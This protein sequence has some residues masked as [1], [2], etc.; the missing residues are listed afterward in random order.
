MTEFDILFVQKIQALGE[1]LLPVM[2]FF[3]ALGYSAVYFIIA[4]VICWCW[5]YSLGLKLAVCLS[6]SGTF[7]EVLKVF[8]H[9]PRPYMIDDRVV[10]YGRS[11][12][13]GMPSGHAQGAA[14]IWGYLTV[15]YTQSFFWVIAVFLI[16]FIGIS[17]IYL[18]VHSPMQVV[19]G[20][21]IG[22]VW[23]S[24]FF[25]LERKTCVWWLK[26]TTVFQLLIIL[27]I[28]AASILFALLRL[29]SY[30]TMPDLYDIARGHFLRI[31]I[32]SSLFAGLAIGGLLLGKKMTISVQAC[33]WKQLIKLM[34]GL[35][36][37]SV[38]FALLWMIDTLRDQLLLLGVILVV[39]NILMGLWLT[40][41][42]PL[43]FLRLHLVRLE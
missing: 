7:N 37:S 27:A 19:V 3:T 24:I 17:R 26:R 2:K 12:D 29:L 6:F 38:F 22:I 4:L 10:K 16:F 30:S 36:S 28:A 13:F 11:E 40:Y 18:G 32:A 23:V 43:L 21:G 5:N 25:L 42:A 31:L 35:L 20:W 9:A 33:W 34:I 41:F 8:F 39:S 14:T 15:H 1:G